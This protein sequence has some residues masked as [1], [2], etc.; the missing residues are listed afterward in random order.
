[1]PPSGGPG[2]R[3]ADEMV[4]Q[5]TEVFRGEDRVSEL[6]ER[7]FGVHLLDR[8]DELVESDGWGRAI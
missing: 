2:R 1:M 3:S 4:G 5:F 7:G 6:L 8:V